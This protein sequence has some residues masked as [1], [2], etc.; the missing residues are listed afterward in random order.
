MS[1]SKPKIFSSITVTASIGGTQV[2]TATVSS[3]D[4]A[5]T[6]V[7]TFD[8]P[9]NVA[10]GASVTFSVTGIISGGGSGQLD[11]QRQVRMAG[12]MT[13]GD[14]GGFGGTG[15]LMLALSLM[16]LVIAPMTGTK[17]RRNSVLLAAA[18]LV[19]ATG[20]VGCG[21]SSSSSGSST[22]G[23]SSQGVVAMNI[24]EGGNQIEITGLPISLGAVTK[25]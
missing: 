10:A 9:I 20:V 5:K 16:G 14:H 22:G 24:M 15:G 3:P 12:I 13:M 2:G 19:I 4:I 11:I 1:V 7:F 25:K 17:R 23:T 6:T 8:T 21:G 18:M